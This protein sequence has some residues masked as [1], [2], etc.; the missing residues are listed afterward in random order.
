MENNQSTGNYQKM[1]TLLTENLKGA[2]SVTSFGLSNYVYIQRIC[3]GMILQEEG[4]ERLLEVK[5]GV[6]GSGKSLLV[7][8]VTDA[9]LQAMLSLVDHSANSTCH[10]LLLLEL[11]KFIIVV[12]TSGN[13]GISEVFLESFMNSERMHLCARALLNFWI[14]QHGYGV[15]KSNIF[16]DIESESHYAIAAMAKSV[17]SLPWQAASMLQASS[18]PKEAPLVLDNDPFA[19]ASSLVILIFYFHGSREY[20]NAFRVSMDALVNDDVLSEE[21]RRAGNVNTSV[22]FAKLAAAI[23]KRIVH[24]ESTSLLLYLLLQ[25]NKHVLDY[26]MVCCSH[27]PFALVVILVVEDLHSL[28][29]GKN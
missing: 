4:A 28:F 20:S 22:S 25:G 12:C 15:P 3:I 24:S 8:Q 16:D 26:F 9:I 23:G 2:S 5:Q 7:D 17:L 1:L 19:T 29:A 18:P 6:H 10:S 27:V 21:E 13:E 11:M 14:L